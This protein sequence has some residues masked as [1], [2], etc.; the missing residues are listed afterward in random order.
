MTGEPG[1]FWRRLA[2]TFLDGLVFFP[3]YILLIAAFHVSKDTGDGITGVLQILYMLILPIVWTGYTVGKKAAGVQIVRVD[4]KK[5]TIFTMLM[6]VILGGLVHTLT[7]G[8]GYIVSAF[9]V[10]LREDKRG[11]HDFIAGTQVVRD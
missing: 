5:V 6:R 7:F 9:M 2:A 1:G 8:I 10:G 11:I 4:G 3:I